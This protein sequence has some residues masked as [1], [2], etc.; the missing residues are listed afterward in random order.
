MR[1]SLILPPVQ[2]AEYPAVETCPYAGC[3]GQHVQQWQAVPKPLRDTQLHE[4]IALRYRGVRCGRT[5]RVSPAGVSHDQTSARLKGVAVLF[6]VLGM[7]YGAVATA[8]TALGWP[9][10]KVA[11][12]YAV[13]DAGAAVTGLRREVV[14]HGG[15]RVVGLGADRTSVR[16]KG[17]WLTV[18]ISVDA[19]RGTVLSLDLL[20]NAEATTLTA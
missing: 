14:R 11:V 2:P 9:L 10:S 5:F 4:V 6:Y 19:V 18:G 15:G 17:A 12:S 3:G 8:L 13:Q 16:C 20:P 1:L 7:S